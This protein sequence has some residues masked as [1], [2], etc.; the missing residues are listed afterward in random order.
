[1]FSK[2]IAKW[3]P[4]KLRPRL[5]QKHCVQIQS[6]VSTCLCCDYR[7]QNKKCALVGCFAGSFFFFFFFCKGFGER[8]DS[9]VRIIEK[10]PGK[11]SSAPPSPRVQGGRLRRCPLRS[12]GPRVPCGPRGGVA[13]PSTRED[14]PCCRQSGHKNLSGDLGDVFKWDSQFKPVRNEVRID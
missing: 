12:A 7:K 10:A 4:S 8:C 5:S 13:V 9:L 14:E 3:E 2:Q 1:M 6:V 11:L